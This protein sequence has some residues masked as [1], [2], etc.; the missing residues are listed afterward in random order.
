M[1]RDSDKADD[2]DD[3]GFDRNV[4]YQSL[5]VLQHSCDVQEHAVIHDVSATLK[6]HHMKIPADL[7]TFPLPF[8]RSSPSCSVSFSHLTSDQQ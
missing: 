1:R 8:T 3:D 6:H 4:C 7:F 5:V 2:D